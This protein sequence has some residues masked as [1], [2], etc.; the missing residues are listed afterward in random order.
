MEIIFK[1]FLRFLS[2]IPFRIQMFFGMLLGRLLFKFL[3]KRKSVTIWNLKKCFPNLN[4]EEVNEIAKHNFIRLGQSIF[5]ICNSYYKSDSKF[6]KLIKNS[7][8]IEKKIQELKKSKNLIL[9]PHTG[10]VDFVVRVPSVFIKLNGMQRSQE[11]K[12]WNKIMTE[13]RG[14]F[15]NKIF[16]PNEGKKLLETLDNGESVLYAPDQDYG[17][18][19][20]IF[21]DFFKHKALT[22]VFPSVLVKRTKCNVYLLTVV[23][24]KNSYIA[25][26]EKLELTGESKENDLRII[27]SAIESFANSHKN[28]YFW[29]HRR[30]KNRP[31]GEDNFY[32]DDALRKTWL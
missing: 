16:L 10:N 31:E 28:E 14:K 19:N 15:V 12:L 7:D 20:S 1:A 29:I 23:K 17:Y 32:P 5:E 11:N 8:E 26:L 2:L 4:E 27:N 18:K 25:D 21:I 22:V 6:L 9:V 24:Q 30:F 3:K 13:G